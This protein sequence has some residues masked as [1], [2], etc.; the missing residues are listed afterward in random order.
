MTLDEILDEIEHRHLHEWN[1]ELS[2]VQLF[3][4]AQDA[5]IW[6]VRSISELDHF[7][8]PC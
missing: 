6:G 8:D 3:E 1:T 4:I 2:E 5:Y 7:L